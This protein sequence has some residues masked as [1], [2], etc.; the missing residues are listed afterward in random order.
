MIIGPFDA[1]PEL[2]EQRLQLFGAAMYVAD[3]IERTSIGSLV[4]PKRMTCDRATIDALDAGELPDLAE[5]LALKASE[6]ATH[7]RDH[8]LN[9]LSTKGTIR[10][11]LIALDANVDAGIEHDSDWQSVPLASQLDPALAICRT[12]IRGVDDRQLPMLQPLSRDLAHQLEGI[13]GDALVCF[14]VRNQSTA[15]IR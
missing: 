3:D 7:L 2:G 13:G 4:S 14:I 5:A 10:P 12:D 6:A 8:P 1:V 9:D 11:R 15:I